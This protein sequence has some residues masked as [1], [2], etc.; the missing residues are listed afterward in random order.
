MRLASV[1]TG[2]ALA[3]TPSYAANIPRK[4]PELSVVLPSGGQH[5]LSQYRGK[6]VCVEFMFTTCPHCQTSAQLLTRL[7]NEYG[8]RGFQVLAVAFNPMAKML[9]PDF[10]RDFKVNFPVGYA[11]RDPVTSFLQHPADEALSVPQVVFV[12]RKGM[13]RG[14]S[15]PR[16]D[17]H[18]STESFM[19]KTIEQ[20]LAEPAA[21]APVKARPAASRKKSTS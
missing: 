2:L 4:A 11:E 5:L 8:P 10:V 3:L 1:L 17:T 18:T 9:V 13:I 16:N 12:D 7:Q 19:R 21:V 20:L 6:V 14:Q 15:L